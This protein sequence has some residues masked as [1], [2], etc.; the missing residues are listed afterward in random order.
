MSAIVNETKNVPF[1][2]IEVPDEENARTALKGIEELAEEIRRDGL[3]QNLVVS[4]GGK[5]EKTYRLVAGFRRAAALKLLKWGDKTVPVTVVPAAGRAIKNLAENIHRDDLP[6]ADLAQRLHD[7]S[8]GE[9]PREPGEEVVVYT[10]EM[11]AAQLG[12]SSSHVTNLIRAHANLS[13]DVKK[14]WQKHDLPQNLI[15]K[16]ASLTVKVE[17]EVPVLDEKGKKVKD[18]EGNV[19][20]KTLKRVVPDEAGQEKLLA[21]WQAAKEKEALAQKGEK[22]PKAETAGGSGD[23]DGEGGDVVTEGKKPGKKETGEFIAKAKE[24]LKAMKA[25]KMEETIEFMRLKGKLEGVE[26]AAGIRT[27]LAPR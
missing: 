5:G 10:K 7:L 2:I 24:N 8:T 17:E 14:V 11:L 15:F 1:N 27:S 26:W 21:G 16:A 25:E 22:K 18:E 6:T 3:L 4:N 23:A 20:M 9:Y 13:T 12:L 19:K